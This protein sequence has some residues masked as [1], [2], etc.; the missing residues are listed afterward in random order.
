MKCDNNVYEK[1][2]TIIILKN[3]LRLSQADFTRKTMENMNPK[4]AD[5]L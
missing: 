1:R 2:N 5:F 4:R 3:E